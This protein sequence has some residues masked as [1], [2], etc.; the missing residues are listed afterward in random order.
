MDDRAELRAFRD[1]ARSMNTRT[2]PTPPHAEFFPAPKSPP[3]GAR[4]AAVVADDAVQLRKFWPVIQNMVGQELR[5]RYQRSVLGFFWTLLNPILMML[6]LTVVFSQLLG[7]DPRKYAI[8][9]FSG[10]VPWG[11]LASGLSECAFCIIVNE[12]L[13]RKIYLPKLV[14]PITRVL[15]NLV[16][17]MLSLVALF[18]LLVPMGAPIS[19]SIVLLPLFLALFAAFTLGLGLIVATLNTF[20]RDCSHLVVVFLQAWYFA[21]PILYP[22]TQLK[23]VPWLLW[24]NP[25]YPFIRL[26]QVVIYDG[27][28]PSLSLFATAVAVAAAS[29]GVGYA[30]FKSNEDKL[31]FRL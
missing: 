2:T 29:L 9:L 1:D 11:L 25:A 31:I 12:G 21:T 7:A 14:F 10:M 18:L 13:I 15:I 6:T 19:A 8:Q 28:W 27:A 20:Y 3:V 23:N 17:T 26:F 5:V 4:L 22:A 24:L 16:T 30:A